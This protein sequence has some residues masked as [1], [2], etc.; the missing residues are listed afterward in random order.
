MSLRGNLFPAILESGSLTVILN[1]GDIKRALG[2]EGFLNISASGNQ[3]GIPFDLYPKS[4][5]VTGLKDGYPLDKATQS[6]VLTG[7]Q[8]SSNIDINELTMFP[9]GQWE[10]ITQETMD[11]LAL[12]LTS[13][14]LVGYKQDDQSFDFLIVT[15]VVSSGGAVSVVDPVNNPFTSIEDGSFDF[16]FVTGSY[17]GS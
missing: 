1:T 2:D 15:G 9:T 16:T 11:S 12:D 8:S 7:Q 17:Q 14:S 10:P 13:G 6:L 4:I 3:E 5:L